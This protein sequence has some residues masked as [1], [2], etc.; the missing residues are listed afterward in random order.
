MKQGM[1]MWNTVNDIGLLQVYAA[2]QAAAPHM[3]D[4]TKNILQ[5]QP[6]LVCLVTSCGGMSYTF[7]VAYEVGKAAT[8]KI[9]G[10]DNL[11]VSGPGEDQCPPPYG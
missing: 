5:E 4:T 1:D 2:C 9:Q 8:G 11:A 6:T 7:N 3:I 10:H